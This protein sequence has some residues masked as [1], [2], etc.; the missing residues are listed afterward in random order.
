MWHKI[1]FEPV[2]NVSIHW[3]EAAKAEAKWRPSAKCF[4]LMAAVLHDMCVCVCHVC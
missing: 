4:S 2:P 3:Q 1:S